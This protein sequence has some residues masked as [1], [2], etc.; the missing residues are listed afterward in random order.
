MKS[1]PISTTY[2]KKSELEVVHSDKHTLS[3]NEI[4]AHKYYR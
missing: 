4:F 1:L 2:V 3:T